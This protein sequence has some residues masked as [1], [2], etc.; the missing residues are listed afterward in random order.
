MVD[1][2]ADHISTAEATELLA[3]AQ[4]ELLGDAEIDSRL[5]FV[6]GVSYRNLMIYRGRDG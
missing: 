2:T 1:F 3:S 6:P 4:Q 5:E